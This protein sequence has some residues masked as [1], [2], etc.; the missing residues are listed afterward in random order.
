[1]ARQRQDEDAKCVM[2]R[3]RPLI[4]GTDECCKLSR[5]RAEAGG[6][7]LE[8]LAALGQFDEHLTLVSGIADAL[9]APRRLHTLRAPYN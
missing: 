7:I 8:G 4:V 3:G 6:P 5:R 1:M 2:S 9:D